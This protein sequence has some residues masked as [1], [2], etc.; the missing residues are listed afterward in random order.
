M[1]SDFEKF[2]N[3][4]AF[5][6]EKSLEMANLLEKS[7]LY[8]FREKA[9][10][11]RHCA[12]RI[13]IHNLKNGKD[14]TT[15]HYCRLRYCPQ[16]Q[17]RKSVKQY[18]EI[19]QVA[20][21]LKCKWLHMVLTVRN[22]DESELDN[23]INLLFSKSTK[24][25]KIYKKP[26]KGILRACEV[27]YN[28]NE[29]TYHPHLHCLIAVNK[30][31]FT[32]RDYVKQEV[33]LKSWRDLI[34]QN[35]N[36]GLYI[37]KVTDKSASVAEVAKYCLKPLEM[38]IPEEEKLNVYQ[39]IFSALKGKRLIQTFGILTSAIKDVKNNYEPMFDDEDVLCSTSYFFDG[40][41]KPKAI[42]NKITGEIYR[43]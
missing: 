24:L 32:S 6:K 34:N 36:G 40:H 22:C 9:D 41:F 11:I 8:T 12:D 3:K 38:E 35:D 20:E 13:E 1:Y 18:G 25:F 17:F 33:L 19:I 21:S 43:I 16:C 30:S 31:Y 14:K 29:K 42:N 26:F 7:P 5:F 4:S 2:L 23:T 28:A 15:S 27:T 37:S 10:I 39:N